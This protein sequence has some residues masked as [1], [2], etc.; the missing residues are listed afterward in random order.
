MLANSEIFKNA[1]GILVARCTE[2]YLH[3]NVFGAGIK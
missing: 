3:G 1:L 2:K